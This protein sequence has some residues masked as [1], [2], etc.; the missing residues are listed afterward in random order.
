MARPHGG[1]NSQPR[2]LAE[3]GKGSTS[4]ERAMAAP[5]SSA[6]SATCTA[7]CQPADLPETVN[8]SRVQDVAWGRVAL[9]KSNR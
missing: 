2:F 1:T 9:T 4:I 7:V 5:A 6:P 8:I 3:A